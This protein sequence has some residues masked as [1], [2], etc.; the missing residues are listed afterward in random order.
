MYEKLKSSFPEIED[1]PLN[2]VP[3]EMTPYMV[4]QRFRKTRKG[5]PLVQIG[6]G[7]LTVNETEGYETWEKFRDSALY[8]LEKFHEAH[9]QKTGIVPQSF[10]LRYINALEFDFHKNDILHFLASKLKTNVGLNKNLFVVG[11]S[12]KMPGELILRLAFPTGQPKGS[13]T[14]QFA[15]GLKNDERALIW[16]LIVNSSLPEI[17]DLPVGGGKWLKDAHDVIEHWFLKLAEG[18]L[19]ESFSRKPQ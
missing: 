8:V 11:V 1:L 16:E 12:S 4:R 6:P 7:V 13:V 2:R 3:P 9:P 10:M 18:E 17:T 15:S 19:L 5:W 14:I